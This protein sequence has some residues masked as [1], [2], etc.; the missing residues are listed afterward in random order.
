MGG[1]E[2]GSDDDIDEITDKVFWQCYQLFCFL[3]NKF[4]NESIP[5]LW[6]VGQKNYCY[7]EF[8]C[9]GHENVIELATLI[10]AVVR[11]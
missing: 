1:F 3:E 7:F 2:T 5:Q 11:R 10:L 9:F 6:N 8:A 4:R